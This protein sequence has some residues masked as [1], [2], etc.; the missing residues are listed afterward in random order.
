MAG[1][2]DKEEELVRLLTSM[3]MSRNVARTL[4]F[5][6]A[7]EECT[8]QQIERACGLRQPEVSV[9]IQELRD[10][11]WVI[12]RDIKRERKGRPVHSYRLNHPLEE[13]VAAIEAE[14]KE[15]IKKMEGA[16]GRLKA[17]TKK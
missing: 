2:T 13:I 6:A 10:R 9:A 15:R 1:V 5:L 7:M 12:K 11:G 14:E 3:E 8:S 16:L 17:L 4:V